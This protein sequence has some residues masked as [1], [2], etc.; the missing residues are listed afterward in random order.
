VEGVNV[1]EPF[2]RSNSAADVRAVCIV[3]AVIANIGPQ[4]EHP[5]CV[6]VYPRRGVCV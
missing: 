2:A 6:T 1:E 4:W 3:A 5:N